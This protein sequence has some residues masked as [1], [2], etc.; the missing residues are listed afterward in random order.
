MLYYK[1]CVKW[2][3]KDEVL[4]SASNRAEALKNAVEE[5]DCGEVIE[6]VIKKIT[7]AEYEK[8]L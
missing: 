2:A 6:K 7:K 5:L 3:E 1:V 8:S 4:V